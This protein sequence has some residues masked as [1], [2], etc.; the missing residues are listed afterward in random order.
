M[1]KHIWMKILAV[2]LI[3]LVTVA[4]AAESAEQQKFKFGDLFMFLAD[5]DA[6]LWF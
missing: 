4:G 6:L 1:K 2:G 3:T 5:G